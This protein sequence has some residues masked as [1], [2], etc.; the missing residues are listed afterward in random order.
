LSYRELEEC[1]GLD[2]DVRELLG[3]PRDGLMRDENG[4]RVPLTIHEHAPAMLLDRFL[5]SWSPARYRNRETHDHQIS[6][7]LGVQISVPSYRQPQQVTE[8]AAPAIAAPV[9]VEPISP[10]APPVEP[11]PAEWEDVEPLERVPGEVTP[12]PPPRHTSL[13]A[14]LEQRAN[15]LAARNGMK[16]V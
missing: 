1:V 5:Q 6:G 9:H 7:S 10:P 11:I 4:A 14:D 8:V 2:P 3:Y 16:V 12:T 13:R 15:E